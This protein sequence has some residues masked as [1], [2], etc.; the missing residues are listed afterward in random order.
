MKANLVER[1]ENR[2]RHINSTLSET[3]Q[4]I[5]QTKEMLNRPS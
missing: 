1:P 2:Y 3:A 5:R 4:T